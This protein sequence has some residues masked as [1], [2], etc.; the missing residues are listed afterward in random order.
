MISAE[1]CV[2]ARFRAFVMNREL[3][4]AAPASTSVALGGIVIESAV[5][6][7]IYVVQV[8]ATAIIVV[9]AQ[10]TVVTQEAAYL[11][12]PVVI[13]VRVLQADVAVPV[14]SPH[15]GAQPDEPLPQARSPRAFVGVLIQKRAHVTIPIVIPLREDTRRS[16][17]RQGKPGAQSQNRFSHAY[18]PLL[19][20]SINT[21]S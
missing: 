4:A 18:N 10:V 5:Q 17:K 21:G 2:F 11:V 15:V 8:A 14:G 19:N 13:V 16:Q 9:V 6:V 3:C 20:S 1:Y 7:S 12:Q